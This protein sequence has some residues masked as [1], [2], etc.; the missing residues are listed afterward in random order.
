MLV[1]LKWPSLLCG[2]IQH[3]RYSILVCFMFRPS[4]VEVKLKMT[5]EILHVISPLMNVNVCCCLNQ[6]ADG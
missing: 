2:P 5:E 4:L 6:A 1:I 3:T